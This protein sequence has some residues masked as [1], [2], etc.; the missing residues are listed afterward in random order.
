MATATAARL[1][2]ESMRNDPSRHWGAVV[3][4]VP[5]G[6]LAEQARALESAGLA[7]I[8]APQIYGPPFVTLAAVAAATARVRL[9]SGIAIAG[10][11]SPVETAMAA[12]DLDRLSGGRFILGLG[13]SVRAWS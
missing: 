1:S 11:R 10:A 6:V 2:A 12:I 13:T 3:P 5:A 8:L 4:F 9:L 7:G